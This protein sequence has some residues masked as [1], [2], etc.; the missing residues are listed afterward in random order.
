MSPAS[1]PNPWPQ[2]FKPLVRFD[3]VTYRVT[4]LAHGTFEIV[5]ILDDRRI[6]TFRVLPAFEVTWA[7]VDAA[8]VREI[9]YAA[10]RR[11]SWAERFAH[12]VG[13]RISGVRPAIKRER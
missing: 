11:S 1:A 10:A 4:R 6:G 5:R 2:A 13:R 9:A 12:A 3:D 7:A 8:T